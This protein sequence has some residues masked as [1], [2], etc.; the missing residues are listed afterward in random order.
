MDA[1]RRLMASLFFG[2]RIV[3]RVCV[4]LQVRKDYGSIA[5][6]CMIAY[7]GRR[8][9]HLRRFRASLLRA[10]VP[11]ALV[12]NVLFNTAPDRVLNQCTP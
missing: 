6:G 5:A 1:S 2:A 11:S 3:L 10:I 8:S 4:F 12:L 7:Q 9:G